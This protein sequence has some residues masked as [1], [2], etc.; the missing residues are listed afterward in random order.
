MFNNENF[1][2]FERFANHVSGKSCSLKD[3]MFIYQTRPISTILKDE[4]F[5]NNAQIEKKIS[6]GKSHDVLRNKILKTEDSQAKVAQRFNKLE[7]RLERVLGN[8]YSIRSKNRNRID[9]E[10][11]KITTESSLHKELEISLMG[12]GFLQI[13]EIF[14]TIEYI[15]KHSDG[16]CLILIDEPDSHIH[17]DLQS[18]LIDELKNHDDSQIFII[19]HNDRLIKKADEGELYYLNAV[20]KNLGYLN[21]LEINDFPKIKQGLAGVLSELENNDGTPLILTEGKT[22][23]KILTI[24]WHKLYGGGTIPYKIISSGIQINE[25]SRSGNADTIRRSLE[26]ISTLTD[27]K[28]IGIFDND[29]EGNEC[30]KGLNSQIF[31]PHDLVSN[32]RKHL[33]K[34]IYGVLLPVPSNRDSFVTATSLTQRYLVIEHYFSNEILES[35]NMKGDLILNTE[36]FEIQGNKSN[37]AE[38]C[39]E[40]PPES[41]ECFRQLFESI[42]TMIQNNA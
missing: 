9:D 20:V 33:I 4:P 26:Y 36:V 13:V 18:H 29:R 37:F 5:H 14:S 35:S 42:N 17:S 34:D 30:F 16:I 24:A 40:L 7:V 15:E 23:Q 11:I 32:I 27:Q 19:T 10:Y 21:P 28:V 39:E 2:E 1:E 38:S 41:F 8:K 3:A 31:E 22:D 12:S 25:D 6:I